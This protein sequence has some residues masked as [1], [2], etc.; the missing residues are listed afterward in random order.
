MSHW[1]SYPAGYRNPGRAA[2]DS[3]APASALAERRSAV[4]AGAR[5]SWL[6][7]GRPRQHQPSLVLLHGLIATAE[8]FHP[9]MDRF[10]ADRH[11][12]ALDF[13]ANGFSER[14]PDGLASMTAI[15][16]WLTA[17]LDYLNLDRPVLIG[18]SHGGAIA[19]QLA[20]TAPERVRGLVLMCPA[21][22]FSAH[23]DLL[24]RFY[25]SAPGKAFAYA[26]PWFPRWV[27]LAG[28]KQMAGP[29]SWTDPKQLEPYRA[30]LQARGTVAH[31]LRLL[32]T[33]QADM[34][35]LGQSLTAGLR[36]PTLLLWG[37]RDRA[38]PD[39]TAQALCRH[40]ENHRLIVF[41]GVGHRPAEEVPDL[42]V[43]AT[44]TWLERLAT[45]SCQAP[46]PVE[47]TASPSKQGS[48][49][50]R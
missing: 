6:E 25:L 18:H 34:A 42:C 15:A 4:I 26:L 3:W 24:I 14:R 44:E 22:P 30:N 12:I 1:V 17:V 19:M 36:V 10:G 31:L 27:Q 2:T 16:Q 9:L 50:A 40:L 45:Q 39:H 7:I 49:A 48:Y 38:V 23:E 29:G 33:W 37:D 41:P 11:V 13:P 5:V 28:F 47:N 8:T 32:G 35:A 20:A 43:Q 21:H 46:T